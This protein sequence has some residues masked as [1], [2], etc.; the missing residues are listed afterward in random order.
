MSV[1]GQSPQHDTQNKVAPSDPRMPAPRKPRRRTGL[2]RQ[3]RA[4]AE[5]IWLKYSERAP[6]FFF[7]EW[8]ITVG[9]CILAHIEPDQSG[10]LTTQTWCATQGSVP[11]FGKASSRLYSSMAGVKSALDRI[12]ADTGI[13]ISSYSLRHQ[14]TPVLRLAAGHQRANLRVAGGYRNGAPNAGSRLPQSLMLGC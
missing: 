13:P 3:V 2:S 8:S 4:E 9:H 1:A 11:A 10:R 14:I 7:F 12:S 6:W 5:T